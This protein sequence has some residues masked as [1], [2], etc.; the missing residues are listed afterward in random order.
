MSFNTRGYNEPL[1]GKLPTYSTRSTTC[2][3]RKSA[4][5]AEVGRSAGF[6]SKG[7]RK[8]PKRQLTST[9]RPDVYMRPFQTVEPA[10][11]RVRVKLFQSSC[12]KKFT[13]KALE[14]ELFLSNEHHAVS[15]TWDSR[16]WY[17]HIS[18]VTQSQKSGALSKERRC[19]SQSWKSMGHIYVYQ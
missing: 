10:I 7:L 1:A 11:T 12:A 5:V 19:V 9:A 18:H 3:A 14:K 8:L 13:Q 16:S 6:D 17:I 4:S 15:K 2:A